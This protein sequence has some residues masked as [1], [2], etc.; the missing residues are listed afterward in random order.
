MRTKAQGVKRYFTAVWTFYLAVVILLAVANASVSEGTLDIG[1]AIGA[2][3]LAV[4]GGVIGF[5]HGATAMHTKQL[6]LS[7]LEDEERRSGED[8]NF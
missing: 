6:E 3:V 4:V 2:A 1:V 7:E 5:I 8:R